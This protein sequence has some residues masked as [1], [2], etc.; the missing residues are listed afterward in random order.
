MPEAASIS[1]GHGRRHGFGPVAEQLPIKP[2][3]EYSAWMQL[4]PRIARELLQ[5]ANA[6]SLPAGAA[7]KRVCQ[8]SVRRRTAARATRPAS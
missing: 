4:R 5:L 6:G 7:L 2:P 8:Q 1:H 3:V